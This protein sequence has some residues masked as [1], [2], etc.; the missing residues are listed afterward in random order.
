[1]KEALQEIGLRCGTDKATRHSYLPTYDRLLA[2]LRDEPILLLEVG[3]WAGA[4]I[5][6]WLEYFPRARI[7]AID[8][9]P[10]PAYRNLLLHP[11]TYF[12]IIDA[13]DEKALAARL[14]DSAFDVVIDDGSHHLAEQI[15]T[16]DLLCPRVLKPRGFYF[17]EDVQ[18][19]SHVEEWKDKPDFEVFRTDKCYD[20]ILVKWRRRENSS[21]LVPLMEPDDLPL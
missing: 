19:P 2:H 15:R 8:N 11:R 10:H 16:A 4:S 12:H 7:H 13:T 14:S 3:I 18:D 21:T 6:M 9:N 17:I 20:D 5:A 1:M